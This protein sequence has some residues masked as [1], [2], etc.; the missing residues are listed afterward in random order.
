MKKGII[1][2]IGLVSLS[3]IVYAGNRDNG[4]NRNSNDRNFNNHM[5]EVLEDATIVEIEGSLKLVN[6][7][8]PTLV[9]GDTT[10]TIK[11][12]WNELIDLEVTNG[13]KVKLEGAEF[14]APMNWDGSEK[15]LVITKITING[16]TTT[17]NHDQN[18][19]MFGVGRGMMG[20]TRGFGFRN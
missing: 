19:R 17:I 13:T 18:N 6:G 2:L 4:Y 8:M 12:P 11:V 15:F 1:I 16:K 7:E 3:S 10:Y 14:N 9:Y 20:D 5:E